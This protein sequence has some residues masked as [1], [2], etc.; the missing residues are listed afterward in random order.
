MDVMDRIN[1]LD[2]K[3]IELDNQQLAAMRELTRISNEKIR[4]V[5]EIESLTTHGTFGSH[6]EYQS[7]GQAV[8]T[9]S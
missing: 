1:Q 9:S 4:V 6:S 7:T 3:Y 5:A 8:K 2:L